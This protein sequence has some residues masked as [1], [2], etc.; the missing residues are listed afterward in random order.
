[1]D[2]S[3]LYTVLTLLKAQ[4]FSLDSHRRIF[5]VIEDLANRGT[6][7]DD[8]TVTNALIGRGQLES[9][10]GA[11]YVTSLSEK[12]DSAV[13]RVTHVEAYAQLVLDKSRRRRAHAAAQTLLAA[14]E[15]P[16][17]N[18]AECLD[19]IQEALLNIEAATAGT[20]ARHVKEVLEKTL[21]TLEEQSRNQGLTGMPT[22]L[23][24]LDVATGGIRDGELWT[25]GAL[26]GRGKTALGVQIL[27]ACGLAGIPSCSFSLEMQEIEIGKR[28]LAAKSQM[29]RNPTSQSSEHPL[30]SMALSCGGGR[31]NRRLSAMDR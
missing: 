30:G 26:P 18:T 14:T 5:S 24:S 17:T 10:G 12:L 8:L 1:L 20:K 3:R 13:A 27:I 23:P 21:S 11:E 9:V 25:V 22:G 4:D 6:P 2:N 19:G 15:D 31:E 7:V 29:L 16:L 28:I